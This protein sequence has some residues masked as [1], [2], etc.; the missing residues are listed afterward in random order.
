[1]HALQMI[2]KNGILESIKQNVSEIADK[3]GDDGKALSKIRSHVDAGL[4]QDKNWEEF[5]NIFSQVHVDFLN[6]IRKENA[7]ITTGEIRL[8]ALLRLNLNT[9]EIA[10]I[11][12][13]SPSSVN[14][15]RYRLRKKLNLT[16]EQDLVDFLTKFG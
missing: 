3:S 12:G 16:R 13:I 4:S 11:L 6:R 2:Q 9:K 14:I 7:D 10:S 8:A 1:M 5:A 15:A